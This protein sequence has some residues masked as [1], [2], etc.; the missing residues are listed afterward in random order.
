MFCINSHHLIHTL[1]LIVIF[2]PS[3]TAFS[4]SLETGGFVGGI[5]A[6][7]LTD[8]VIRFQK[9]KNL[10]S[11]RIPVSILF[12]S[13][14]TVCCHLLYFQVDSN[15]SP[16]L[17]TTIGFIVGACVCGPIA[18]FGIIATET[19]PVHLSGTAHAFVALAANSE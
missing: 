19:A 15:S 5:V 4:S 3:A 11:G 6:G 17:I 14:L 1:Y 10:V 9:Q 16:Y 13:G 8:I 7:W 12:M 2:I 18:L